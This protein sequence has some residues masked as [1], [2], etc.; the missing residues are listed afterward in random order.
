MYSGGL[1]SLG[2]IY[3]L[4]T[5]SQY[6]DYKLHVHHVHQRNV[7]NRNRAEAIAVE[8]VVNELERMGY[9][10]VYSESEIASQ[11]Y[12]GSFMYDTDSVNFFAGY[13]CSVNPSIKHVAMGMNANDE[14]HSLNE[15]RVRADAI[16]AAFTPVKKIYPVLNMSKREIYNMLPANLR[17]MFWS[18]RTP[19]YTDTK[20]N[21]CGRC[22]T[23]V[24]LKEAG[25]RG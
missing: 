11:P 18:C 21:P 15:R 16:L 2:T 13:I 22:K 8:L 3:R 23:C 17:N 6:K 10:F 7:E 5:D 4:L 12:N 14:N 19:V 1:D 24:Q 25:I 9:N 20:V